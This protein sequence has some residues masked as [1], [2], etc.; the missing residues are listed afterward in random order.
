[1]D[2]MAVNKSIKYF[3][4]LV[5]NSDSLN[6]KLDISIYLLF[7]RTK[8]RAQLSKILFEQYPNI[9]LMNKIFSASSTDIQTK[10]RQNFEV[11]RI[12]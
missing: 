8:N 12:G 4:E 6:Q 1:M 10:Q 5:P 9:K 3:P 7:K 11:S 2:E